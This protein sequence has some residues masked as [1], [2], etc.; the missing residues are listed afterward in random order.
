MSRTT[1]IAAATA[2]GTSTFRLSRVMPLVAVVA[3]LAYYALLI[4]PGP[5][6]GPTSQYSLPVRHV[7]RSCRTRRRAARGRKWCSVATRREPR[8]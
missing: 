2:S 7:V 8:S 1:E 4:A 6:H 3:S 5:R